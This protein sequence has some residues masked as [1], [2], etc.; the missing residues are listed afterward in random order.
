M[1]ALAKL[2]WLASYPKS[3]NTWLRMFLS[4][5]HTGSLDINKTGPFAYDD[6]AAYTYQSIACKALSECSAE[7]IV[8]YRGAYLAHLLSMG[9][10]EKSRFFMKTHNC[11]GELFEY[12]LIP[13]C[14]TEAAFYV[15]R[16][17][18]DVAVSYAHHCEQDPDETIA[19]M[20]NPNACINHETRFHVLS[21]WSS[22]VRSWIDPKCKIKRHVI[23]YED[24]M[25]RP[26]TTFGKVVKSLGWD[27]D[28]ER[29]EHAINLSSF[30]KLKDQENRNGFVERGS[31]D[32]EFFRKGQIGSW[33]DEL[34]ADQVAKIE[35]DHGPIMEELG[36]GCDS[37][38]S[39]VSRHDRDSDHD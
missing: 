35:S 18:R 34:S 13:E 16:D 5:Y 22:H 36:Y 24:M 8:A 9:K 11:L 31:P 29:L 1:A 21:S 10:E 6:M 7:E 30:D 37:D 3:G 25:Q 14:F 32:V 20:A 26:W 28:N 38:N 39:G 12:P 27:L 23:R 19:F 17:P 33:K 4:A 2:W 15:V